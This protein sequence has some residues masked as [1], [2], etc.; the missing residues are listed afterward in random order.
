[1]PHVQF[2]PAT[3]NSARKHGTNSWYSSL[4]VL[5]CILITYSASSLCFLVIGPVE[6]TRG[7]TT[8]IN[9]GVLVTLMC[10]VAEPT[11]VATWSMV[12]GLSA[13]TWSAVSIDTAAACFT[14]SPAL[15]ADQTDACKGYTFI[16]TLQS[17]QC[18]GVSSSR[19][20]AHTRRYGRYFGSC[21][22]K[23]LSNVFGALHC[24][25]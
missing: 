8:Y 18:H 25:S 21:G 4:F 3:F 12:S 9:V 1:M 11:A 13:L 5:C 2:Q 23:S 7:N 24:S 14:H 17:Q 19:R 10:G 22:S 20:T 16:P 15:N 6:Q